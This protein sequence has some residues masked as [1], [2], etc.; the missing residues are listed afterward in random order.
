MVDGVVTPPLCRGVIAPLHCPFSRD[1]SK[2]S[3][4]LCRFVHL[5]LANQ[6]SAAILFHLFFEGIC[7]DSSVVAQWILH[8][9]VELDVHIES[10]CNIN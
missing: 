7:V 3:L 1:R 8:M 4:Y 5:K 10:T 6:Y 9:V 2:S